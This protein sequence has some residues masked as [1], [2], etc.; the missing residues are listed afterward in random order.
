MASVD[1]LIIVQVDV[2]FVTPEAMRKISW[3][4]C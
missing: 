1:F 4:Y 2:S 3:G